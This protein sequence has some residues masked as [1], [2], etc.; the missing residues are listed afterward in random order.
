MYIVV[1]CHGLSAPNVVSPVGVGVIGHVINE[2]G[3]VT[4]SHG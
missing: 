4:P 3:G 1:A 2:T